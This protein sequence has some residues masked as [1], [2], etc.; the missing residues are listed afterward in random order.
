MAP[1]IMFWPP[2]QETWVEFLVPGFGLS[3]DP[4]VL[5]TGSQGFEK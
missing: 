4:D 1:V 5:G 2:V 3:P